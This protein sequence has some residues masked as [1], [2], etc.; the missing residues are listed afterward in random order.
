MK[1]WQ[2]PKVWSMTGWDE[3]AKLRF[4]NDLVGISL[5]VR[6]V[7]LLLS[8]PFPASGGLSVPACCIPTLLVG[9]GVGV[10]CF[11]CRSQV[12]LVPF[13]FVDDTVVVVPSK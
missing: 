9:F 6:F 13:D 7:R 3:A 2:I 4:S 5:E 11:N 8:F 1:E 12:F 10:V